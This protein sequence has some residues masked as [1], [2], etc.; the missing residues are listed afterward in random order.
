MLQL[1]NT[2]C[3]NYRTKYVK[4]IEHYKK[5]KK[6]I[7]KKKTKRERDIKQCQSYGTQY[8]RGVEHYVRTIEHNMLELQNTICYCY[9][10]QDV[11]S[12][13]HCQNIEHYARTIEH[14]ML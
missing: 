1:Q 6:K 13:E 11:T 3:Q 10:T 4:T 9:R 5:K 12:I 2:I 7:K 14:N 8:F